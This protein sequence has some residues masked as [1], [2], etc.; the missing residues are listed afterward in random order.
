MAA[1]AAITTGIVDFYS[2]DGAYNLAAFKAGGGLAVIHKATEGLTY[3]DAG[4]AASMD[5]AAAYGL[6]RGAY[7]FGNESSAGEAQADVF[8]AAVGNRPDV[9]LALDLERNPNASAGTMSTANAARFVRRVKDRTGRWPLLY[10]GLSDLSN[11]VATADAASLATLGQC[12][13]WLAK[14]GE[15]PLAAPRPWGVWSLWQYSNAADGPAD[16]G[17]FPRTTPGFGRVDRNAFRGTPADLA[18]WWSSV[19]TETVA[20]PTWAIVATVALFGV[21]AWLV[22]E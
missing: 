1:P 13:L 16:T 7:H 19:G 14:Y 21:A 12:A 2:G 6:L 18:A 8:L 3:H 9:L 17:T 20:M 11:R 5:Q 22:I 15:V 4:F 10:A